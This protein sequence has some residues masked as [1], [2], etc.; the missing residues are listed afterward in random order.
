MEYQDK[1][2]D[3]PDDQDQ[4]ADQNSNPLRNYGT[5]DYT[6]DDSLEYNRDLIQDFSRLFD[7][8]LP[9]GIRR[10][11]LLLLFL[12]STVWLWNTVQQGFLKEDSSSIGLLQMYEY[13]D[14]K[15]DLSGNSENK[16]SIIKTE[17]P[18]KRRRSGNNEKLNSPINYSKPMVPINNSN[19]MITSNIISK[20]KNLIP[21]TATPYIYLSGLN[22]NL[23]N[24]SNCGDN[25]EHFNHVYLKLEDNLTTNEKAIENRSENS[26]ENINL[27]GALP[28]M[29]LY[30]CCGSVDQSENIL[31]NSEA[32][33]VE[34]DFPVSTRMCKS[35]YKL[36]TRLPIKF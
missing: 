28:K 31:I 19:E 6:H 5:D 18:E 24:I 4:R 15:E 1:K 8:S 11:T 34:L 36:K 21:A 17:L 14:A 3:Q 22:G 16:N 27:S 35:Q 25:P 23:F 26:L 20:N 9:D 13:S 33:D 29:F 32:E 7:T 10:T 12:L 2:F 30:S